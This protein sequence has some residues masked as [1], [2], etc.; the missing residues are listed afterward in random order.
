GGRSLAARDSRPGLSPWNLL[1]QLVG[2][3]LGR[4]GHLASRRFFDIGLKLAQ[5]LFALAL[6]DLNLSNEIMGD[7]VLRAANNAGL[8]QLAL[9]LGELIFFGESHS[10]PQMADWPCAV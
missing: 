3:Q 7:G 8:E 6:F 10:K 2:E 4:L 9:R 1:P 5:S